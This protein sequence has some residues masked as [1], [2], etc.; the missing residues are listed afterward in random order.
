MKTIIL[1]LLLF[2]LATPAFATSRQELDNRILTLT[3]KFDALQRKPDKCIP[4][5]TLAK[6]KGIIL[7]DRTKAGFIFAYQGGG[8]VAMVK[9]ASGNWS[10]A[11]FLS[12]NE[13]SLGFQIGGEQ[14]FYVMLLMTTNAT[15]A[16][17][18]ERSDF[19][20]EARGTGGDK[21]EGVGRS[22]T[23]E[24]ESVIVYTDRKGVFGAAAIKGGVV[25]PDD[26]ANAIYYGQAVSMRDILFDK[27]VKATETA[28]DLAR[29]I[30]DHAKDKSNEE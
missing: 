19:G 5:E 3:A 6:A 24:D 2:G 26:E 23:P 16:L 15:E 21:S 13:A 9:D 11:A 1:A 27:E 17:T 4:R 25:A 18:R 12:A 8:G 29:K 22:F 14:N 20:G 30:S 7:L 28:A 10:P